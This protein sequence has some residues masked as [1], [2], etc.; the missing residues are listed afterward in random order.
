MAHCPIIHHPR[1]TIHHA[2]RFPICRTSDIRVFFCLLPLLLASPRAATAADAPSLKSISIAA[3]SDTKFALDDLIA[4]FQKDHPEVKVQATYG[5]S[6]NFYAQLSQRA[7]F[8]LFLSADIRYP[9]Q[10]IEAGLA[11]PD[12]KFMYAAGKLVLWVPT[13]SGLVPS[14]GIEILK[15]SSV[16]KI[17]IANPEHA[18][19]GKAAVAAMQKLGVYDAVKPKLVYAENIAQAAQFV[20]SGAADA[21][22]IALS[23]ALAPPM[24]AK[25]VWWEIPA[26]A[27]PRLEQGGVI[28]SWARNLT[29]TR[30]FKDFLL[31]DSGKAVLRR[32]GFEK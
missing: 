15:Y 23:L 32:Y 7:P 27:Y 20:E 6:G 25:G 13:N 28:L 30:Q 31:S 14:K 1:F 10:L 21:G 29:L 2:P 19:Y 5:S 18:P 17:A 22:L 24:K 16:K 4:T 9:N 11:A 26:D 12:S 8:D 3:A